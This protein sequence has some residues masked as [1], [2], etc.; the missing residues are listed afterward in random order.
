M[1]GYIGNA[2]V[3]Q[4]TQT[5][6]NFTAT[7]G[8]TSFATSGYTPGYLDVYLNGVRLDES[9]YTATNGSDVVLDTGAAVDDVVT[10]VAFQTFEV[11]GDEFTLTDITAQD[12]N[13]IQFNT[14]EG[15]ERAR[16]DDSGNLLVAKTSTSG[17]TQGHELRATGPALHTNDS[18][19]CVQIRRLTDDG[20]LVRFYKDTTYAGAIGNSGDTLYVGSSGSN[21]VGLRFGGDIVP[22]K[23][24]SDTDNYVNL[25]Q[26]DKRFKDLYLSGG[27]YL[28]GTGSANHLDD[29]EEG[30]WTP[31]IVGGTTSGTGTY[32]AQVGRYRK[33]G[34][35]VHVNFYIRWSAHT[36]TGTTYI[37]GLPFTN[38]SNSYVNGA[39]MTSDLTWTNG[40]APS[41]HMTSLGSDMRLYTSRT[42]G[43]WTHNSMDSS[44]RIIASVTY[45]TS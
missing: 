3:P 21:K 11:A 36:G 41:I 35:V 45:Y 37:Q 5:R 19:Y 10:V 7:A 1:A 6:D 27:V 30:T 31:V 9:D 20:D 26:S 22:Q 28:G 24:L 29:Y 17:T 23:A 40:T 32:Q 18:E 25:G 13:G 43:S 33:V 16:I 44:G 39:C 38:A 2:P 42:N 12:S 34:N 14:D 15:T 8:Q 4:A